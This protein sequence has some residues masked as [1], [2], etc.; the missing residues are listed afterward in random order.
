MLVSDGSAISANYPSQGSTYQPIDNRL[1]RAMVI[2]VDY[3]GSPNNITNNT[4]NPQL[5]Y[6]VLILGG[7]LEGQRI[8]NCMVSSQYGGMYNYHE[9]VFRKASKPLTQTLL[10]DQDGD[11]VLVQF[12][13]G[14]TSCPQIMGG[15]PS[16]RDYNKTGAT[17]EDGP[18]V[19]EQYN[20]VYSNINKDG[21]Y[22]LHRKGGMYDSDKDY[23][24][25]SDESEYSGSS[26]LPARLEMLADKT[27]LDGGDKIAIGANGIELLHKISD[28]LA[29]LNT[30]FTAAASHTHDKGDFVLSSGTIVSGATGAPSSASAWT[31][32]ASIMQTIQT[33]IDSIKTTL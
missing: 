12:L 1:F 28:Q 4:E 17:K 2:D 25:P 30:L 7:I 11:V 19:V 15:A 32:A 8:T 31:T 27:V 33:A 9:R 26:I 6:T 22:K 29:Q 14:D 10:K 5:T 16:P 24:I 13:Q 20:G 3:V 21:E 18:R 23:F